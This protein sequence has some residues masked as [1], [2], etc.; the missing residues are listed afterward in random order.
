[1]FV[2]LLLAVDCAIGVLLLVICPSALCSFA[3]AVCLFAAACLLL[4][5]L[6]GPASL[7]PLFCAFAL[8]FSP[9]APPFVCVYAHVC[10]L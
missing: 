4:F 2:C 9:G 3:V 1:L 7:L 8:R 6:V 10:L 5:A